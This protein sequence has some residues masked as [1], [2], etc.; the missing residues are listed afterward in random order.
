MTRSRL[1]LTLAA[2]L[3]GLA[4]P[5]PAA[6]SGSGLPISDAILQRQWTGAWIACP[7]A[8]E[9]DPGVFRFRKRIDLPVVPPRFVVHVSADQRFVLHVNGRRVGIGPSRGDILFWRFATFDLAP[10]L[11]PG[12]NLVSAVVWNFGTQAP[13]AQ[14]TDRTGFVLQGEGGAVCE[15]GCLR[16]CRTGHLPWP[17]MRSRACRP[18]SRAASPARCSPASSPSGSSRRLPGRDPGERALPASNPLDGPVSP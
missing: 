14:I 13:A 9:R 6:T 8:P 12:A 1:H 4:S 10:F 17:G 7:A 2:A 5:S 18:R 16:E 15:H 3:V 11:K